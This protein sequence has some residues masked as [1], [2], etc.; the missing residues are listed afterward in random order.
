MW[1]HSGVV[2]IGMYMCVCVCVCI[3]KLSYLPPVQMCND[4]PVFKD[5]EQLRLLT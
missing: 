3:E 2:N 5:M 4:D 1:Q